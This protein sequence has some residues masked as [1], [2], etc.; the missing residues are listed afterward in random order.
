MPERNNNAVS[1]LLAE[2]HNGS[3]EAFDDL[4]SLIYDELYRLAHVVRAQK[5]DISLN[6]TALVHEA[7]LQ[8]LPSRGFA[9]N[10]RVHFFRVAAR[11]MRQVIVRAAK[12][13]MALKRGGGALHI[14][15]SESVGLA[16]I[17]AADVVGL[18]EA[19][20]RLEALMP[21]HAQVIECRYFAGLNVEET[22]AA[23]DISTAT[24][25]RDWRT[26]R[27]WLVKELSP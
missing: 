21:R 14:T 9:W 3:P 25:K 12:E 4:V 10:D 23:L 20:G 17:E 7:Y 16:S 26:A 27:A 22:A 2:A 15:L 1:R 5:N 6:T 13:R 11:A 24:V 8:L 19:L 18:D